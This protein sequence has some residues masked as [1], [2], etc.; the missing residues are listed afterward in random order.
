MDARSETRLH[1]W[2]RQ[3]GKTTTIIGML[4]KD[5][6]AWAIVPTLQMRNN[7]PRHLHHRIVSIGQS[8]R[9]RIPHGSRVI[10]DDIDCMQS[11]SDDVW[12]ACYNYFHISDV[13]K[14]PRNFLDHLI[15]KGTTDV[16]TNHEYREHIKEVARYPWS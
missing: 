5:P 11:T 7:Y 12:L 2:D 10:I 1:I 13:F 4:E 16:R 14:S 3:T 6:L 9:T 15:M 8:P